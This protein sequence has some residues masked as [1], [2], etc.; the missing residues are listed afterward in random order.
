MRLLERCVE[1]VWA[2]DEASR[3]IA[4]VLAFLAVELFLYSCLEVPRVNV[5]VFDKSANQTIGY[6]TALTRLEENLRSRKK[7]APGAHVPGYPK[8]QRLKY[9][10]DQVVH[11]GATVAEAE[12]E[13]VVDAAAAL[14][15]QYCPEYHGFSVRGR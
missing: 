15:E 6:E 3:Q 4:V 7:L 13:P 2:E 14:I 10:R 11:K 12:V 1:V 9:W 8:L 5:A